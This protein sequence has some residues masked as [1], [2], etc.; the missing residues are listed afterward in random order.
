MVKV[1]VK[2]NCLGSQKA[3]NL[4]KKL[5]VYYDRFNLSYQPIS[6]EELFKMIKLA[7]SAFELI[8]L[9]SQYFIDNPLVK[10]RIGSMTIKELVTLIGKNPDILTFP[11]A[12]QDDA[13]KIEKVLLIGFVESE[14]ERLTRE[15]EPVAYYSNINK[16]FN[17]KSCCFYDE[18]LLDDI[19]LIA[20]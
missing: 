9:N 19:N 18:A 1:F 4:L 20:K 5:E 11:I 2:T 12:I 15:P 14:W 17:F 16:T 6:E 8:N 3:E 13:K 7:G 10:E